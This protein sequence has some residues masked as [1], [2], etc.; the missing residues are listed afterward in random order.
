MKEHNSL[1]RFALQKYREELDILK[2][3]YDLVKVI[4]INAMETHA[5]FRTLLSVV[6]TRLGTLVEICSRV[7]VSA[8]ILL[9]QTECKRSLVAASMV[10]AISAVLPL[11]ESHIPYRNLKLTLVLESSLADLGETVFSL[12][13]ASR[14]RGVELG[15]ARKQT[16]VTELFKYKQ[17][18]A[19]ERKTRQK[20][21]KILKTRN[22][23][24][25]D[26]S[27]IRFS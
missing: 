25:A 15:H 19:E 9:H 6:V 20:Q 11:K 16:V 14:M 8:T 1:W 26:Q 3:R 22:E 18:L 24:I 2:K 23:N 13:F 4:V 5:L 10:N 17:L 21:E 12:N 7:G 27:W